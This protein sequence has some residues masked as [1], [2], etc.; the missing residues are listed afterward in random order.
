MKNL[1]I[2]LAVVIL[3]MGMFAFFKKKSSIAT[4]L[5]EEL[6]NQPLKSTGTIPAWLS[7]T[8]IRNGPIYVTVNGQ[9]NAHWFDGLAMLHAFSFHDGQV[10]YTNKFLRTDAYNAVF[11]KGSLN[12][13]GFAADP[14]RSLFR[15]FFTFLIPLSETKLHNANIN[16][17][18]IADAY[19]ALTEVPLPICFDPQTLETLGVLDY[20][21]QLPH[22]KCW[23][24]AHPHHDG[25]RKETL[26]Y[27]IQYGRVTQYI[28]YR[29][30]DGSSQRE[31]ISQIPVE[32]PSYMH[33][34]AVT[35]HYII[36][37]AFP[38]IVKPLDLIMKNRAFIKNF[39]WQPERGTQF[40][41]V[42][43]E[44][45]EVVGK[46]KTKAFFSFHHANAFEKDGHIYFDIVCYDDPSVITG[47]ATHFKPSAEEIPSTGHESVGRLERF[48]LSLQTGNLVAEAVF[49][50]SIEFPRINERFDGYPYHYVY[51][52]D[53]RESRIKN[54]PSRGLYK[55]NMETREIHQW[56]EAG[57]CP[58]EPVFIAAPHAID[59]DEG[60]VLAVVL[61]LNQHTSFLLVLDG[62]NFKEIGRAQVKHAIPAGLHGQYFHDVPKYSKLGQD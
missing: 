32:E 44:S 62:K 29:L 20:Q 3:G 10:R 15:R 18:K 25:I 40:I 5:E 36:F 4:E 14:C 57:C 37:T 8:L 42:D 28:L 34:F 21:D 46:Y 43:R 1:C 54:E 12:Y 49:K 53:P 41:V 7:G 26:N 24:S 55:V 27:L 39:S 52:A 50:Q 61:D 47:A 51:L 22:G 30:K 35:E 48:A 60:V 33:S 38:F 2:F 45:G 13:G 31:I 17:A 11:E 58:G 9:T 59:E 56:Q 6:T 16:V 23:E 19:V